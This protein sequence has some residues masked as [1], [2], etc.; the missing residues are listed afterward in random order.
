MKTNTNV[1]QPTVDASEGTR[2]AIRLAENLPIL[3][4]GPYLAGEPGALE[5]L[6]ADVK[7][8]QEDLGFFAIVNHGLDPELIEETFKQTAK[9]F[10]L[11]MEEKL[12]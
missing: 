5:Q 1:I 11:S 9:L 2:Q 8:I 4:V 7:L 6:A 3:D 12:K 10:E